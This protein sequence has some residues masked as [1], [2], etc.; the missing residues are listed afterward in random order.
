MTFLPCFVEDDESNIVYTDIAGLFDTAGN[1][2][3]LTNIFINR[4]VFQNAD[5]V[6]FMFVITLPQI[7]EGRGM[8]VIEF[9][10]A[11]QSICSGNVSLMYSP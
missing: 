6:R 7:F 9:I 4:K 10:Q 5:K 8:G 1:L 2:L 3:E 11:V